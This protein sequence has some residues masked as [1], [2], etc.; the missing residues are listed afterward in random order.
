M[1][2]VN[3]M[4]EKDLDQAVD[5]GFKNS[6]EFAQ[7]FLSKTKFSGET[8]SYVWSRSDN[9]WGRFKIIVKNQ[10]TGEDEE[11]IRDSETDILVVYETPSKK[12]FAFHIENK[13]GYGKFTEYQPET[14]S[15]RA[16]AWLDNVK[17]GSYTDYETVLIAPIEF[18]KRNFEDAK[19]FDRFVSHEEISILLPAFGVN[20]EK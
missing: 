8:A 5:E 6:D 15:V 18:Y 12:R 11:I 2:K 20:L 14:Y 17:Y 4:S 10:D 13:L 19:Q 16:N 3:E 1:S 9:P 7:W